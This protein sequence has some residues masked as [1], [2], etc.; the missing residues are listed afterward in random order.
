MVTAMLAPR[1]PPPPGPP[2][3]GEL[4]WLIAPLAARSQRHAVALMETPPQQAWPRTPIP[5]LHTHTAPPL[6]RAA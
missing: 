4:A 5:L 3:D 2:A 6:V 1:P